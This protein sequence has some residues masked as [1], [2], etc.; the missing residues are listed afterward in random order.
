MKH[1]V[2]TIFSL[3][4]LIVPAKAEDTAKQMQPIYASARLTNMDAFDKYVFVHL[5]TLD[6]EIQH[7]EKIRS[8]GGVVKAERKNL[9]EILAVP[10]ELFEAAGSADKLDTHT[11]GILRS[12]DPAIESG[13]ILIPAPSSVSGK[14][15]YYEISLNDG[16][17]TL[18]KTGEKEYK[19]APNHTPMNWTL[20]AFLFSLILELIVFSLLVRFVFKLDSPSFLKGAAIVLCAQ[21]VTLPMLSHIIGSYAA[22][23]AGALIRLEIGVMLVEGA[24]Y[25][26]VGKLSLKHALIAS[27]VANA[28]FF[29]IAMIA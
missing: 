8:Q 26:M 28:L 18:T 20:Y 23:T 5:E 7:I 17:L 27:V 19:D 14:D 3:L 25:R 29:M 9:L 10:K 22:M 11:P 21:V 6:G 2:L 4:F 16:E 12:T 13:E 1:L 15:V 24:I